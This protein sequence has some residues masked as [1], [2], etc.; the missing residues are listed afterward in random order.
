MICPG[1]AAF[2]LWPILT[3]LSL[4]GLALLH[5]YWSSRLRRAEQDA[6]AEI[7][8]LRKAQSAASLQIHAQQKALLDSMVEGLLVL[9]GRGRISLA[10]RAFSSLFGVTVDIRGRTILEAV[11]LHELAELLDQLG[12]RQ[13]VLGTELRL[14][15]PVE[16]WVQVN[17]AVVC[18]ADGQR[19]GTV[20][21]FHDLTRIKQLEDIRKDFVAN[22]S[23]ELRTPLSLIQGYVETLLDGAKDNPEVETRFLQTIERNTG[24]LR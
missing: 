2:M 12:S 22:V 1:T 14:S 9:D 5:K 19:Q 6:A 13:E 23:H 3:F 4:A 20:L 21:V 17:G 18:G 8:S 11:R 10:N 24:R 7:E 15:R 16:R